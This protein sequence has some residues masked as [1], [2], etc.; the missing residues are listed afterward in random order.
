MRPAGAAA[1]EDPHVRRLAELFRSHPIWC[2][3][4][5]QIAENSC[6][7]VYFSHRPGEPWRL[8]RRGGVSLLEAGP[9]QDPDLAFCFPPASIEVLERTRGGIGDFAVA[10]FRLALDEDPE[11]RVRIRVIAPFPRLLLRGYV[12]LLLRGGRPLL[13]FGAQHGVRS[14]AELR[15][16]VDSARRAKPEDWEQAGAAGARGPATRD[17]GRYET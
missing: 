5:R 2:E 9:A 10:L 11:R 6:A 16:L 17:D 13:R 4:A 12:K 14:L 7:S 8:V 1:S 15:R 3:A